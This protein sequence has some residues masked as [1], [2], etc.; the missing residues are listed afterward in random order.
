MGFLLQVSAAV[1]ALGS[2]L[3]RDPGPADPL[4][5]RRLVAAGAPSPPWEVLRRHLERVEHGPNAR[6][7]CGI[8]AQPFQFDA[9]IPGDCPIGRNK[10]SHPDWMRPWVGALEAR[11][12]GI[13]VAGFGVEAG[14]IPKSRRLPD[15]P[16]MGGAGRLLQAHCRRIAKGSGWGSARLT[17][18]RRPVPC[19][20]GRIEIR[21]S[22]HIL[23]LS[24]GGP[25]EFLEEDEIL[26]KDA[27]AIFLALAEWAGPAASIHLVVAADEY[28]SLHERLEDAM[29]LEDGFFRRVPSGPVPMGGILGRAAGF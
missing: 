9:R 10:S 24:G 5:M 25:A 17:L 3:R 26:Q 22:A 15:F 4:G 6:L 23:F 28:A 1:H 13:A 19:R 29:V 16:D 8:L 12:P 18:D 11:L 27:E 2:N 21:R 7:F 20:N 14:D